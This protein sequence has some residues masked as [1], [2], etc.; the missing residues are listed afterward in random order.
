MHDLLNGVSFLH[1]NGFIH[2]DLKPENLLVDADFNLKIGDLGLARP[3]FSKKIPHDSL[4]TPEVGTRHYVPPEILLNIGWY[5]VRAD[6]WAVGCIMAK[7]LTRKTLFK[8]NSDIHQIKKIFSL[9]G[10][11]SA[12]SWPEFR[13]TQSLGFFSFP[14]IETHCIKQNLEGQY[15]DD[16]TKVSR[17]WI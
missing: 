14:T 3:E 15:G 4:L 13:D 5:D 6:M 1:K 12:Q 7:F 17:L 9:L 11:E 2:R 10:T 8:G 16:M